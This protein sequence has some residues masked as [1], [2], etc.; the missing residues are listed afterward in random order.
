MTSGS[1][2]VRDRRYWDSSGGS[3]ANTRDLG[4]GPVLR[5]WSTLVGESPNLGRR[6]SADWLA[7]TMSRWTM[8]GPRRPRD[9]NWS[10]RNWWVIA[11]AFRP[12]DKP[13]AYGEVVVVAPQC[14]RRT[15]RSLAAKRSPFAVKVNSLGSAHG[16]SRASSR[17]QSVPP[18][19]VGFTRADDG[20]RTGRPLRCQMDDMAVAPQCRRRTR[21]S[22]AATRSLIAVKVNSL[23]S[24]H[25]PSRASSRR[26]SVHPE[27]VGFTRADDGLRTGR[28]LADG[29]SLRWPRN[30]NRQP[31]WIE[32]GLRCSEYVV[33][34]D[35]VDDFRIALDVIEAKTESLQC[36]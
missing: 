29:V 18:E 24:A 30:T 26:Q 36:E 25:L 14:R 28:P 20:L 12:L 6:R 34:R 17:S 8:S 32:M 11:F 2:L 1:W 4:D 7:P 5:R 31:I 27:P 21:R 16:P 35:C 3:D 23:D 15:R 22:L 19:P 13:G 10:V 9:P 33:L